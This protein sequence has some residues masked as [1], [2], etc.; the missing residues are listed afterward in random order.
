M[1]GEKFIFTE[2]QINYIINNWGKESAHSMKNRFG[3][4]WNAVVNIAKEHGLDLP[5]SNDWTEEQIE[6]LK[7]L[8]EHYHYE[9]IARKMGKTENAIYL[10][11]RRLGIPLIQDRRKWSKEDEE[12]LY[13]R[14]G[15]DKIEKIASN[16]KRSFFSIKVKATRMGLGY[17]SQA[18]IDQI[19]VSDISEILN[20]R[21]ERITDTWIKLGLKL[22]RKKVSDNYSYYC[23]DLDQLMLF[24]K[25]H[26]DLWNSQYLEPNILGEEPDWL[27]EKRKRDFDNPPFEYK[28]WTESEI[29]LAKTLLLQKYD[30]EYISTKVN[31]SPIGVAYKMRELGLSYKLPQFWKE[32]ELKYL[33]E[34]YKEMSYK[35][36]ASELNRTEKAIGAK[37]K[38]L[39]Y[40]KRL[41]LTKRSNKDE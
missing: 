10:K 12:Y 36:I 21:S 34:H 33:R 15:R 22:K 38:E 1:R 30:Y 16:M 28:R 6:T 40:Q 8:S 11:A 37:A 27:L 23:I 32:K 20:V 35:E 5:S 9:D 39:G 2:E 41:K 17:M 19:S 7:T 18:N 4:S 25:E 29:E 26:Q 13:E 24:L 31:H 14:W 3:C